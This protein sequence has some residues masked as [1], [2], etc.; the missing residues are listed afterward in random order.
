MR[1]QQRRLKESEERSMLTP[2]HLSAAKR[3]REFCNRK[4]TQSS[5]TP[6]C[7]VVPGEGRAILVQRSPRLAK[8][9]GGAR[10]RH[11]P[12][13]QRPEMCS[14]LRA[15]LLQNQ[16]HYSLQPV[17]LQATATPFH[18][19]SLYIR[20]LSFLFAS[21]TQLGR[22]ALPAFPPLSYPPAQLAGSANQ[23]SHSSRLLIHSVLLILTVVSVYRQST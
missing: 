10:R 20:A 21:S 4:V 1:K 11:T 23:P 17:Y 5:V 18:S 12:T 13:V 2:G 9:R 7:V 6:C 19:H 8:V 15:C 16:V 22:A 3:S 14:R